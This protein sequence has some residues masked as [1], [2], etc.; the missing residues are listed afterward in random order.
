MDYSFFA[1][2]SVLLS[3]IPYSF[4]YI[5]IFHLL[6]VLILVV[7]DHSILSFLLLS[8]QIHVLLLLL[9]ALLSDSLQ[10]KNHII[11]QLN[12]IVYSSQP[13]IISSDS[14]CYKINQNGWTSI[15]VNEGYCNDITSDINISN[16]P[17][18][19]SSVVKKKSL[20]YVNSLTISNN[21]LLQTIETDGTTSYSTGAF[22]FLKTFVLISS[23][24]HLS[25]LLTQI[26]LHW[27]LF[28]LVLLLVCIQL[29]SL[30]QVFNHSFFSSDLPKL[31]SFY[32]GEAG[33]RDTRTLVMSGFILIL[34]FINRSS[35]SQLFLSWASISS[36]NK[37]YYSLQCSFYKWSTYST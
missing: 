7:L 18:L 27:L 25:P 10:L 15:Y 8:L 21:P 20:M 5:K 23:I 6:L 19:Q 29:K 12:P 33:L 26:I 28:L 30:S 14:N 4:H 24:N 35:S 2:T 9:F 36:W 22:E 13:L 17:C 11:S 34:L 31:T 37:I 32:V 16:N 1:T 3:S